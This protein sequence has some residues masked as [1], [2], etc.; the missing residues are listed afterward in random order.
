MN[1]FSEFEG[2]EVEEISENSIKIFKGERWVQVVLDSPYCKYRIMVSNDRGRI[3]E[4]TDIAS[5]ARQAILY[6][7]QTGNVI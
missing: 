2:F 7:L 1:D 4:T 6:Y 3:V 5:I